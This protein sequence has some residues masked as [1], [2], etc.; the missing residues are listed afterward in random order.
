MNQQPQVRRH[1]DGSINFDFYRQRAT[2]QRRLAKQLLMRRCSAFI[3][4][5]LIGFF[6]H[7]SGGLQKPRRANK[8]AG[9]LAWPS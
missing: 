8:R 7:L 5:G 3:Y 1:P 9:I 6:A 4:Q 2:R